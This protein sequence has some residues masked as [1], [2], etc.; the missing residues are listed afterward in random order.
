MF[1]FTVLAGFAGVDGP[2]VALEALSVGLLVEGLDGFVL[3]SSSGAAELLST[4]FPGRKSGQLAGFGVFTAS[5]WLHL[6]LFW[7][8]R[9]P[10]GQ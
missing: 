9:V 4:S 6:R 3:E 7:S 5:M 2:A 1:G 10:K 8:Q